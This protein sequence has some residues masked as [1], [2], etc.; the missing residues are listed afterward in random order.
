[1]FFSFSLI[2]ATVITGQLYLLHRLV[3]EVVLPIQINICWGGKGGDPPL[4][5]MKP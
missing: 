2:Y 1:M 4:P 3:L 5:S